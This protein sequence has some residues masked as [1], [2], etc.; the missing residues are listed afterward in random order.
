MEEH[1]LLKPFQDRMLDAGDVTM[2]RPDDALEA[3]EACEQDTSCR[4]LG[5]D[6][7]RLLDAQKLLIQPDQDFSMDCHQMGLERDASFK[8][9]R[10]II[11]SAP[12]NIWFELVYD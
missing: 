3:L 4:F 7:F 6:G 9:A 10:E 1:R 12:E 11:N 8:Y 2:L 5:F